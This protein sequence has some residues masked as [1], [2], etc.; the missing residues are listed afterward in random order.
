LT[1]YK[2]RVLF[3]A[4]SAK[5][6]LTIIV[7]ILLTF[8]CIIFKEVR[9]MWSLIFLVL[10]IGASYELEYK[11]PLRE[12]SLLEDKS[13]YVSFNTHQLLIGFYTQGKASKSRAKKP[14]CI[15]Y[16]VQWYAGLCGMFV[17]MISGVFLFEDASTSTEVIIETLF[18]CTGSIVGAAVGVT[19]LGKLLG[20]EGSFLKSIIGASIG[21]VPY[22]LMP[23][24]FGFLMTFVSI[25]TGAVIGYHWKGRRNERYW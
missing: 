20:L 11:F 21:V 14:G 4:V 18:M 22:I 19:L 23:H 10:K 16:A 12:Y 17:G 24:Y 7:N 13:E 15:H 5:Y 3:Q 6:L 9:K 25:P 8:W 2:S 1:F